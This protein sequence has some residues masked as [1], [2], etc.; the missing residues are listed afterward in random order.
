MKSTENTD[1]LTESEM[2]RRQ[3]KIAKKRKTD[4]DEPDILT[5]EEAER[6]INHIE[7]DLDEWKG[8]SELKCPWVIVVR[9]HWRDHLEKVG[10]GHNHDR[11]DGTNEVVFRFYTYQEETAKRWF[12]NLPDYLIRAYP[13]SENFYSATLTHNRCIVDSMYLKGGAYYANRRKEAEKTYH[14]RQL[15]GCKR[16][17]TRRTGEPEQN[18]V[19][20]DIQSGKKPS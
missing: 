11:L 7:Y 8:F 2:K 5:A 15:A 13:Y 3:K 17:V 9:E 6:E 1:I 12:T 16:D 14:V 19:K 10:C 20:E 18:P 4:K